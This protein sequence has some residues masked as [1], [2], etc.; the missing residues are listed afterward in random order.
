MFFYPETMKLIE[1]NIDLI[2]IIDNCN[3][4]VCSVVDELLQS[5]ERN[6]SR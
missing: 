4:N 2:P 3:A 6:A 1:I 5:F